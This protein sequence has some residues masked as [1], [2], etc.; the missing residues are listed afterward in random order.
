MNAGS[1]DSSMLQRPSR[2][3]ERR[4][5]EILSPTSPR[6]CLLLNRAVFS[7]RKDT[8]RPAPAIDDA[9]I[10][11]PAAPPGGR[12]PC[13][14]PDQAHL[15]L[16]SASAT[17]KTPL[18]SKMRRHKRC[19]DVKENAGNKEP[20][21]AS[22]RK[23]S[24]GQVCSKN[25]SNK[26]PSNLFISLTYRFPQ[27][28]TWVQLAGSFTSQERLGTPRCHRLHVIFKLAVARHERCVDTKDTADIK[29]ASTLKM[30]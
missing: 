24:S 25:A 4:A 7:P 19:I 22:Q 12:C 13:R 23:R 30:L 15:P 18:T 3:S 29:G 11:S 17:P 5:G 21:A 27:E 8:L 28:S 26:E 2:N 10:E 9:G 14:A 16:H 20:P 6:F 1:R